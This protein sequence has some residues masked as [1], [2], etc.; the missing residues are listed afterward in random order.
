MP[1]GSPTFPTGSGRPFRTTR[2]VP[3]PDPPED[4]IGASGSRRFEDED[5]DVFSSGIRSPEEILSADA[6]FGLGGSDGF[7]TGF[8]VDEDDIP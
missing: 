6:E 7:S 8:D 4:G 3:I 2:R 1:P 5:E